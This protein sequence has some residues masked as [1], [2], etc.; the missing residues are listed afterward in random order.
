MAGNKYL[1][2]GA[3]GAP[4]EIAANDTSAGAGDAGKLVALNAS[5]L[6]DNSMLP[7]P[8]GDG[9]ITADASENLSAGNFVNIFDDGGTIAVR[10]A[11]NSNGRQADGFVLSPVTS[12]NPA[13]VYG[14]SQIN[15]GLSGL[16][17]GARY[18]LGTAGGV[19]AT[20]P[21]AGAGVLVQTLGVAHTT[22]ALR[23]VGTPLI[24]RA[25]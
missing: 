19:T 11:D 8:T 15:T 17:L 10:L 13:T 7:A 3:T 16:T 18:F 5:G 9:T 4:T 25:A 14:I 23:F 1:S 22:G 6:I 21:S 24:V 2:T 12:G 20:V